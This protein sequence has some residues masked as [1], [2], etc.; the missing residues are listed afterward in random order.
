MSSSSYDRIIS[1]LMNRMN[2]SRQREVL[3][4][5]MGKPTYLLYLVFFI[6]PF[7]LSQSSHA[8]LA[9][10]LRLAKIPSSPK[11]RM[12]GESF[13]PPRDKSSKV[14]YIFFCKETFH[15]LSASNKGDNEGD[16]FVESD[17]LFIP[18]TAQNVRQFLT[19]RCLQS[20]MFLLASTRDLHTVQWLDN[21]A[22]PIIVNNYWEDDGSS[23]NP[24]VED[25]FRESDKRLGSKL[26]NYH[27]LSAMNTTTFPEW[28]SF[29]KS[30]LEEP[31][32]VLL[33]STP[34]DV[35]KRAYSEIDIDIEPAR[36]CSR[37]LSVREQ[38]AREMVG[39]L[40]A[41]ANMGQMIFD[42]YWHNSKMRKDS[43]ET[44]GSNGKDGKQSSPYG[45]D[46]PSQ[47][48]MNFD[49]HDD[50]EFAP[51]PLRKGNFDLL[52][53]LTTQEAVLQL[54][55]KGV[56]VD[57][58]DAQ[59]RASTAFLENF[60][61]E[62]LITHFVGAQWYGKGDDFIEELMLKSPILSSRTTV[63]DEK[64]DNTPLIVE[65]LRIAEQVLLLRDKLA[66]EWM[67]IMQAVPSEHTDIR[68]MQLARLMGQ[69]TLDT[70]DEFQ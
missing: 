29:F 9:P 60:Y 4:V 57:Q 8:F 35:G 62:R 7:L 37:M 14:D 21:F 18:I 69:P 43:K 31:D 33:I 27:G 70:T 10:V 65:P 45:F 19:Q 66:L 26:L 53:L 38:I 49:P 2:V 55:K 59:N 46:R 39:D 54:L 12:L 3:I 51:S 47:M 36:L 42:S 61:R 1:F 32:T 24:G 63:G 58:D 68:R 11:K 40:K 50:D 67:E 16:E 13:Y 25:S 41:I 34:S 64:V 52:Y 23:A 22:K 56:I 15:H 28:D 44:K 5:V 6:S 30:L 17:D 20:F 48:Y